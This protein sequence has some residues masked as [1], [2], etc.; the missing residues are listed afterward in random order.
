MKNNKEIF[1]P[2]HKAEHYLNKLYALAAD[3][4]NDI[5]LG[6]R[7][8]DDIHDLIIATNMCRLLDPSTIEGRDIIMNFMSKKHIQK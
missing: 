8:C 2:E 3:S 6:C 4:L 5:S 7:H 1:I